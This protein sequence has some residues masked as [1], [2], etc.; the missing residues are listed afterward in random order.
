MIKPDAY[1]NIGKIIN[2][3]EQEGFILSN[4]KMFRFRLEDAQVFYGEHKGKPFYEELTSF[5]SSDFVVGL[6]LIAENVISKWRT[7]IGPTNCQVARVDA[8]N[9]IRAQFGTSGV[10]NACHGSDASNSFN[11]LTKKSF[12]VL[13]RLFC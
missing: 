8:P 6:E 7:L 3:I 2:I 5:I 1:K 13:N 4:L 11:V 9:S 10:R 12:F